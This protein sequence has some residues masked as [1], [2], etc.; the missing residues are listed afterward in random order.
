M[1]K[2]FLYHISPVKNHA[3][4]LKAGVEP[5]F[6]KGANRHVWMVDFTR[7]SWALAHCALRHDC[8]VD[9]LEVWLINGDTALNV[10]KIRWPGI[11]TSAC[12]QR[13]QGFM[14]ARLALEL[15]EHGSPDDRPRA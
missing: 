9:D 1:A 4:I 7:L 15:V 2:P 3:S 14:S 13:T 8:K 10:H 5:M 6:S 12:R 11:F